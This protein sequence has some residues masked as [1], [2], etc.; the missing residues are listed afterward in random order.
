MNSVVSCGS[1]FLERAT[2]LTCC[3]LLDT[4]ASSWREVGQGPQCGV[5]LNEGIMRP[6]PICNDEMHSCNRTADFSATSCVAK[7]NRTVRR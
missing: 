7:F 2:R 1:I 3:T 5:H 6:F 4:G